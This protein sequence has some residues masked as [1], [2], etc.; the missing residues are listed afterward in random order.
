MFRDNPAQ[1]MAMIRSGKVIHIGGRPVIVPQ[2]N[3]KRDDK[4]R[5][6]SIK[7]AFAFAAIYIVWGSTYLAIRYAVETIPPLVTAGIRHSVAG[8]VLL[9]WACARGYRPKR[10]HWIAGAILGALFFL[11]GHGS[12]HWAEQHVSSGWRHY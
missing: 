10:E 6:E 7:L 2:P 4:R 3:P 12:L 11:I 1:I 5:A 9:V 8:S